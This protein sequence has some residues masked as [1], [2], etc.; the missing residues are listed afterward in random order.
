MESQIRRGNVI[1]AGE[2]DYT[3]PFSPRD[4]A[5][6][7][8][9]P[10]HPGYPDCGHLDGIVSGYSGAAPIWH[11]YMTAATKGA[12]LTW[13]KQ[14]ADVISIGG[15]GDNSDFYLPGTQPGAS[16]NCTYYGPTPLP[17]QTCTYAGPSQAPPP[18]PANPNPSPNPSPGPSPTPTPLPTLPP[19]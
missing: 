6:Y 8:L 10:L 4:L 13:Y 18:P 9:K 2:V 16:T 15:Q 11:A 7:G 19:H 12:P 3:Y 14:P 5:H 1:E 17:T